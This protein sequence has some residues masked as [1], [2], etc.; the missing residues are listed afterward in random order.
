[1]FRRTFV[2]IIFSRFHVLSI[3]E[4]IGSHSL[5]S[6]GTCSWVHCQL[7]VM[8][9][10]VS[11]WVICFYNLMQ[12]HLWSVKTVLYFLLCFFMVYIDE[13]HFVRIAF[14]SS[15]ILPFY[16]ISLYLLLFNIIFILFD[17]NLKNVLSSYGQ[18]KKVSFILPKTKLK[19]IKIVCFLI[20][21]GKSTFQNS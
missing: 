15:Y 20:A 16:L 1:M 17:P 4:F 13:K 3:S 2:W 10:L 5:G 8:K 7:S 6:S 19:I 12:D 21:A 14:L 18:K 9:C 11:F